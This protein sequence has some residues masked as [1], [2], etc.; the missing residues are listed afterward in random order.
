MASLASTFD[1]PHRPA[2][3][4]L[5][6]MATRDALFVESHPLAAALLT[7]ATDDHVPAHQARLDDLRQLGLS[8][9]IAV[10][11]LGVAQGTFRADLDIE[12]TA[13]I[14]QE[15]HLT[16]AVLRNDTD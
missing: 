6:E 7:G 4:I 10:L 3:E 12:P 9:V 13:R 8:Q 11:E 2:L 14:L 16:A 5:V 15:M 1:D